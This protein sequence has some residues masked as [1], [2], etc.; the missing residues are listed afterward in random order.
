MRVCVIVPTYSEAGSIA[1]LLSRL[2]ASPV[3]AD[4][5]VVDDG[6]PDGTADIVRSVAARYP[7]RVR[8][9]CREKKLGIG[10]A[11]LLGFRHALD[12][13]YDAVVQMD[14]DGSHD[15]GFLPALLAGL[16]TC[17][18]VIG[19]RYVDGGSTPGWPASRR[20][21]SRIGCLYARAVLGLSIRDATGGF[22]A[23]RAT[24]LRN[25]E[26]VAI[27][28]SGFCFQAEVSYWLSRL[29]C[30]IGEVPI[31]FR[32]RETG[33]SKLSLAMLVEGFVKVSALRLADARAR[34]GSRTLR[35]RR[36]QPARRDRTDTR[37]Y[38]GSAAPQGEGRTRS[39]AG[40][41]AARYQ[42]RR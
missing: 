27:R 2:L 21:I 31:E 17:D 38:R 36:G 39:A 7:G 30:R 1:G 6:S 5:L 16:E 24:A 40:I 14:A 25:L 34:A 23:F 19:S 33:R 10:S 29:G 32:D 3:N 26:G 8:V 9:L 11:Y 13:G 42:R 15:P 4:V 22:K 35:F 12:A 37:V 41:A 20:A 28:S 18:A